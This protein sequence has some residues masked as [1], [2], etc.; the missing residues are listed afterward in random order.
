[1]LPLAGAE[2]A[3]RWGEVGWVMIVTFHILNNSLFIVIQP[4][5]A[6]KK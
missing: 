3:W 5:N 1:M 4:S 6:A 2:H